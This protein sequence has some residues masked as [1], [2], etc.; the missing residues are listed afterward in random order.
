MTT[1]EF[2]SDVPKYAKGFVLGA[3]VIIGLNSYQYIIQVAYAPVMEP[4]GAFIE[5]KVK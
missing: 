4:L 2:M 5:E 1:R 3:L